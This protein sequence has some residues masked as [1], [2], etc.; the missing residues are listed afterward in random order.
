MG[1]WRQRSRSPRRDGAAAT[2]V[3]AVTADTANETQGEGAK[4]RAWRGSWLWAFKLDFK[5][6]KHPFKSVKNPGT[7]HSRRY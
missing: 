1:L 4:G 2:P 3:L 5:S 6:I 7:I